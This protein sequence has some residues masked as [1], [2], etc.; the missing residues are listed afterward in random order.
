MNI[1]SYFYKNKSNIFLA[2]LFIV[3]INILLKSEIL[4]DFIW[5][6]KDLFGDYKLNISWLKWNY[7]GFDAL[8][9]NNN[10]FN[11]L[12]I[13]EYQNQ[14]GPIFLVLPFNSKLEFFYLNYLYTSDR[15][16]F[17]F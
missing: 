16:F 14:Y 4:Y 13:V 3:I 2:I 7:L 17:F 10:L 6:G 1:S 11:K 9:D 15:V 12:D 8:Q 5:V